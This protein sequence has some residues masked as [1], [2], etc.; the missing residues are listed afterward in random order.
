LTLI[1]V[2]P[3]LVLPIL[4]RGM[5]SECTRDRCTDCKSELDWFLPETHNYEMHPGEPIGYKANL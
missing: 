3:I 2:L 5:A 4:V 1:L